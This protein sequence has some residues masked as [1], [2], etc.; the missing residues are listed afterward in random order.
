MAR[1]GF[2]EREGPEKV[3]Q[4]IQGN[5]GVKSILFVGAAHAVDYIPIIGQI[6]DVN[7]ECRIIFSDTYMIRDERMIKKIKS[8]G[9]EFILLDVLQQESLISNIDC[10]V[11]FGIFSPH[12]LWADSAE[13]ALSNLLRMTK[14]GGLIVASTREEYRYEF[15]EI[16]KSVDST[17]H[18]DESTDYDSETAYDK[19]AFCKG[20][21]GP[22]AGHDYPGYEKF[23]NL[24]DAYLAYLSVQVKRTNFYLIKGQSKGSP[25]D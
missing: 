14:P 15:G 10:I 21:K 11:A 19:H 9:G 25:T 22:F 16:I 13:I 4:Y 2:T 23:D 8:S 7:A 3:L 6:K 18:Y 24:I 20:W 5:G 17:L 1:W 12:V